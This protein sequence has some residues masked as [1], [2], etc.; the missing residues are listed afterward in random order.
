MSRMTEFPWLTI[1]ILTPLLG[2]I[3]VA[4][5][6]TRAKTAARLLG[7]S[8][9]LIAFVLSLVLWLNFDGSSAELQFVERHNWVP[10]LR[11]EYFLGIDGLGMLMVL[12]AALIVPFGM[13][14]SGGLGENVKMYFSLLLFLES[15]LFGAFT[16]LNF[17]HWFLFWELT[18]VP[19]F[20]LIRLWGGS[21][22]ARAATQFF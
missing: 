16:A 20:F 17:F 13:L 18:L 8:F 14:A 2:A 1:L 11:V 10:S 21:D 19:A 12:L 6:D 9:A 15:G 4:G 3:V 7:I 5:L 22:R